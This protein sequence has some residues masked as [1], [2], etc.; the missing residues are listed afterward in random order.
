MVDRAGR[1]GDIPNSAE[2]LFSRFEQQAATLAIADA[3]RFLGF[4]SLILAALTFFLQYLPP[5]AV[6]RP[7]KD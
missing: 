4:A 6:A 5:P 2:N 3:Y 7:A 1:L